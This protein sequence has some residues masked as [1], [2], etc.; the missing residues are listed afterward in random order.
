MKTEQIREGFEAFYQIAGISDW[1][2]RFERDGNGDYVFAGTQKCWM[3]W[4]AAIEFSESTD[5]VKK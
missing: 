1:S 2:L 5:K 4:Q 3:T